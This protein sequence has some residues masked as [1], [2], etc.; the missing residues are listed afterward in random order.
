MSACELLLADQVIGQFVADQKRHAIIVTP[1]QANLET[2]Q[3]QINFFS[4]LKTVLYPSWDCFPYEKMSP[5]IDITVKRLQAIKE[6]RE[7]KEP[8]CLITSVRGFFQK[9]S[10][11]MQHSVPSTNVHVGQTYD[12]DELILELQNLGYRRSEIVCEA[13]EYA[14]RGGLLDIFPLQMKDPVRLD[15]FGRDLEAIRVFDVM[16]QRTKGTIEEVQLMVTRELLLTSERI[17]TFRG[18]YRRFFDETGAIYESIS[19]G[20]YVEGTEHWLPLCYDEL[21]YLSDLL[22]NPLVVLTQ[23]AE[24][25]RKQFLED[26]S[27]QYHNRLQN[28]SNVL[29]PSYLYWTD[30]EWTDYQQKNDVVISSIVG[31][32]SPY[33]CTLMPSIRQDAPLDNPFEVLKKTVERHKTVAVCCRTP[34]VLDRIADLCRDHSMFPQFTDHSVNLQKGLFIILFPLEENFLSGDVFYVSDKNLLGHEVFQKAPKKKS[35]AEKMLQFS[36]TLDTGDFVVHRDHGIALYHGLMSIEVDKIKHDCLQLEYDGGDK[37]FLPIENFDLVSRYGTDSSAVVLDK[38]GT[39]AWQLRKAKAKEKIREVATYL[40]K[41]AAQRALDSAPTYEISSSLYDQFCERFPF[42]ETDDQLRAMADVIDDFKSGK[43]MDRLICGD[44]GFGK[45]EIAL[46]AAFLAVANGYQVLIVVPTTLLARQH[47]AVFENRF[48]GFPYKVAGIS[49]LVSEGRIK[50][51][52]EGFANGSIHILVTTHTAFSDLLK[53]YHLGLVILDEEQHFG[54]KQKEKLK[55]LG[56]NI[57][58]LTLT[59][60]PIPR[61]LQMSL[62]GIRDLSIIATPPVNRLAVKTFVIEDDGVIVKDAIQR[63]IARGG[64]AFYVTPRIEYLKKLEDRL[65]TIGV[66]YESVNGKMKPSEIETTMNCFFD[67]QF[68]VLL[69]TN[70]IE[71]GIDLPTVNTMIIHRSDLFGLSQLY[72]LRGRVGRARAQGFAYLTVPDKDLLSSNALK[73]L[74][75]MQTLDHLGASFTLASHDLD[76]RGAGNVVGEEQSGHIKEVGIELY[77]S[78]L[79]EAIL[80]E[81]GDREFGSSSKS[82][83]WTPQINLGLSVLIPETYIPDLDLRLQIYKQIVSLDD[84]SGIESFILEMGDRFGPVPQETKNLLGIVGIKNECLKAGIEKID[85]GPKGIV[86]A[87]YKNA[88]QN[89]DVLLSYLQQYKQYVKIRADQKLVFLMNWHDANQRIKNIRKLCKDI[90]NL[91][92]GT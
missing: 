8:I 76:I 45:T 20:H 58:I 3:K 30:Q 70:I 25:D 16:S 52:M 14:V 11:L 36:G 41:L 83:D 79:Q 24:K 32:R 87:F 67:R 75:V 89:P 31:D 38:L 86:F 15:F 59:A 1:E 62:T 4:S 72:Q 78:L 81:Q 50:N 46:R 17:T 91:A 7:A 39:N 40:M 90:A 5:S 60:T 13:G 47:L 21:S 29:D 53:N 12:R 10:P 80:M 22:E 69:A 9:I 48:S 26:L 71:S 42:A 54:V 57:H 61:T 63:E 55:A 51:A 56:K 33:L 74:K 66:R 73:R 18:Q 44:V 77:Q 68:D 2:I 49:R 65:N 28:G 19:N 23:D 43:P 35:S 27:D 84:P 82:H 85:Y 37:L 92:Q 6:C 34:G 88:F 64:Q